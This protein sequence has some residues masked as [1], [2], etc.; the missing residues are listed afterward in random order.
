VL[1]TGYKITRA[2]HLETLRLLEVGAA[3]SVVVE[4]P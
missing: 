3:A 1:L 2:T 4:T